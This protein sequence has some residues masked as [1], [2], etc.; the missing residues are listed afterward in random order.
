MTY[1]DF[2]EL[3][4]EEKHVFVWIEYIYLKLKQCS[5]YNGYSNFINK[6]VVPINIMIKNGKYKKVIELCPKHLRSCKKEVKEIIGFRVG[7]GNS[8]D[9]IDWMYER[10]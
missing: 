5:H 10:D 6:F 8:Q 7:W 3:T 2:N 4:R 9:F 1:K